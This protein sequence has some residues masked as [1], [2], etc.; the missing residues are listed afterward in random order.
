M[1]LKLPITNTLGHFFFTDDSFIH[2]ESLRL[3]ILTN[4]EEVL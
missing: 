3:V 4:Q 2:F 1:F